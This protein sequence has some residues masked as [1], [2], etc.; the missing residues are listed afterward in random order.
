M[1]LTANATRT[2]AT[3]TIALCLV[4]AALPTTAHQIGSLT[5]GTE[6]AS[7]PNVQSC[8]TVQW[9][10]KT[11]CKTYDS[12]DHHFEVKNNCPRDVKMQWAAN[13][14]NRPIKR[15][16]ESGKPRSQSTATVRPGKTKKSYHYCPRKI[17]LIFHKV[18]M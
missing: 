2:L 12:T 11:R 3:G 10:K 5:S 6:T 1:L 18:L 7:V 15:G 8:A 17:G 14:F 4:L 9:T 16:A 13:S